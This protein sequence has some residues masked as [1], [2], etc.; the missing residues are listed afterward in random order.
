MK[1][2]RQNLKVYAAKYYDN[3]FCLTESEFDS[4]LYKASGIKKLI[5]SYM[6][7][8]SV[9]LKLLVNTTIGF[10]N[11]FEHHAA[12]EI[13]KF[14][15]SDDQFEIMNAILGF[16]SLPLVDGYSLDHQ[17]YLKIAEEYK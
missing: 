16:L 14:K 3:P 11:V 4:D 1:L 17:V 8:G 13:I 10:Y 2:S 7:N 9:N 5:S 15:L 6:I 12:T